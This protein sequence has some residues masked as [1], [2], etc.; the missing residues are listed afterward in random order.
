M[1]NKRTVCH[2]ISKQLS[3]NFI[4]FPCPLDG[5][6]INSHLRS[7][8]LFYYLLKITNSE[9]CIGSYSKSIPSKILTTSIRLASVFPH[10]R[11][12]KLTL[13]FPSFLLPFFVLSLDDVP[14]FLAL[15]FLF[16][17]YSSKTI[18]HH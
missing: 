16:S 11:Q 10:A 8:F 7:F 4:I 15:T 18:Q 13:S 5:G 2:K 1:K 12:I 3:K 14:T 9:G 17:L 6:P